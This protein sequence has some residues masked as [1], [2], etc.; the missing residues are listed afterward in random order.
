M[1][2]QYDWEK[3]TYLEDDILRDMVYEINSYEISNNKEVNIWDLK[4]YSTSL[5][6]DNDTEEE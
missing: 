4:F 5:T 1:K 3:V 6:E 2:D